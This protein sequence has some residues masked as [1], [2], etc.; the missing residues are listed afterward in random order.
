[1]TYLEV[2][3]QL[4]NAQTVSGMGTTTRYTAMTMTISNA[5]T[6]LSQSDIAIQIE[7]LVKAVEQHDSPAFRFK[8][9]RS[10]YEQIMPTRLSRYFDGIQ[11]M[12]DLFDER[13]EY[14]YSEHLQAFWEACQHVGLERSPVG[15]VCW[16]EERSDHLDHH[17]SMNVLVVRIRQLT[18]ELEYRRKE[19]DRRNQARKQ[20]SR[21]TDYTDAVLY[22]YAR[23]VVVR[24]DLYY[25]QES[26]ARLRVEHVFSDLE[27]LTSERERNPIFDHETGYICRVEQGKDRGYHIHAAFFFNGAEVCRDIYKARLIGELWER[28]TGGAGYYNNCNLD[29]SRYG[30]K[31]GIGVIHRNDW[32]ARGHVHCAMCYLVKDSQ[33]LRLKPRGAKCLRIGSLSKLAR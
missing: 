4:K 32:E 7:R 12:I 21:V 6:R 18:R 2:G 30:D 26:Q 25:R 10:G 19:G 11:Q 14:R 8:S 27:R 33:Q 24:V 17:R 13:C 31:L 29:K 16:D 28:I 3:H 1:M 20:D 22:R 23:T 15:L 5:Y 9:T